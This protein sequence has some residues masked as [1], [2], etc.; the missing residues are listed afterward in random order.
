[1]LISKEKWGI[2]NFKTP[3]NFNIAIKRKEENNR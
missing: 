3:E 1:M 2:K